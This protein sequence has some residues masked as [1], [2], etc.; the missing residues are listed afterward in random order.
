[1]KEPPDVTFIV[2]GMRSDD[3]TTTAARRYR[4]GQGARPHCCGLAGVH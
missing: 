3:A 4:R 2:H 1:L